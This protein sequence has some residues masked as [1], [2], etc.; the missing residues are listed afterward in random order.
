[1]RLG[2]EKIVRVSAKTNATAPAVVC[3]AFRAVFG[4][5]ALDARRV[6]AAGEVFW[7]VQG[8]PRV[9]VSAA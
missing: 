8:M 6:D 5:V 7:R 4:G 2:L 3:G 9:R 1:M